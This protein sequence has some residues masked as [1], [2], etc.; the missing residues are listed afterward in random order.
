[1][2]SGLSSVKTGF[3]CVRK[4]LM[5]KQDE[6]KERKKIKYSQTSRLENPEGL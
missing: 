1:M 6:Q 5:S 4:L 3:F 2:T